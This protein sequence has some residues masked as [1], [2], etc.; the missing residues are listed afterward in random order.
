VERKIRRELARRGNMPF[1]N[2]VVVQRVDSNTPAE[3]AG[4]RRGDMIVRY[5]GHAVTDVDQFQ[6][7]ILETVP[8]TL[9]PIEISRGLN[10]LNL[11]VQM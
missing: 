8:G 6:N 2:A 4:I 7:L 1:A 11:S 5:N 10:R 9:V 3:A